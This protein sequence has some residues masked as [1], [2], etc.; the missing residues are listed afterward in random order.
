MERF[1]ELTLKER[2]LLAYTA[3]TQAEWFDDPRYNGAWHRYPDG[4][5]APFPGA[6]SDSEW[7]AQRPAQLA[8]QARWRAIATALAPEKY[9][10]GTVA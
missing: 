6:L 4:E 8:E 9:P 10:P 3:N 7:A 1:D 5:E 2:A